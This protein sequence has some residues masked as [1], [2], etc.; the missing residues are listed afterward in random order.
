MNNIWKNDFIALRHGQ[1]LAN[2][3]KLIVSRPPWALSDQY[4]LSEVGKAQAAAVRI[5]PPPIM[6]EEED[7]E[8]E[9]EG[10]PVV[11]IAS[12]FRRAVETAE[13]VQRTI[14]TLSSSSSSSSTSTSRQPRQVH[15]HCDVRL[16][17]RDFGRYDLT[18]DSNYELVWARDVAVAA[19]AK[20]PPPDAP[21]D[22]QQQQQQSNDSNSNDNNDDDDHGVESVESVLQRSRQCMEEWNQVYTNCWIVLVAHGDVLQI[23]QT[24]LVCHDA[25]GA[26]TGGAGVGITMA[27]HQH[28]SLPHLETA[29]PR[30]LVRRG[31]AEIIRLA[32]N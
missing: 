21:P 12:D 24:S 1:S 15:L 18:S 3:Q 30:V 4:G 6:M 11:L 32:S 26:A 5:P 29:V 20:A 7:E 2:V 16:R 23:L 19:A 17:E 25:T 22:A 13:I 14:V 10:R 31:V 27:P 9:E 8:G 28:R